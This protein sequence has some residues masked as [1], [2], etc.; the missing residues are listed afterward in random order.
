MRG[1]FVSRPNRFTALIRV[2]EEVWKYHLRDPG[3]LTELLI[4]GREV[5]LRIAE[6]PRRKTRGEVMGIKFDGT[7]VLVNSSLHSDIARWL[8]EGGYIEALKGWRIK[9]REFKLKKSRIDFL[10]EKEGKLCLLEVKGCT[11]VR[12][13]L[14]LFPDAPTERGRRHVLEL[15]S[16]RKEGYEACILFLVTREDAR[17]FSPNWEV[18][19]EFSKSLLIASKEGVRLISYKLGFNG[20]TLFP[21][22][23]LEVFLRQ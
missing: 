5:T 16:A 19:S 6:R 3:R 1:K 7:W 15:M 17:M 13:G 21:R 10:L 9:R 12:G 22:G 18:D 8:I 20:S 11:L 2:G 14:A 4:P 23:E